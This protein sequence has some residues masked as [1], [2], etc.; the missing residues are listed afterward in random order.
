MNDQA[1][2][3]KLCT[4]CCV[5]LDSCHCFTVGDRVRFRESLD[6]GDDLFLFDLI[7]DNGD[8]VIIRLVCDWAIPPTQAVR[9]ADVC[10]AQKVIATNG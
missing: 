2:Q 6:P 3:V 1:G 4:T 10:K 8:R 7:E 9:R 5:S